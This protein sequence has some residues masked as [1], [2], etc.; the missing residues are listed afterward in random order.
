M[1]KS[2]TKEKRLNVI[3]EL[4]PLGLKWSNQLDLTPEQLYCK[5][6]AKERRDFLGQFFT[7]EPIARL[8]ARWIAHNQPA[9][10]LDPAVGPGVLAR[11]VRSFLPAAEITC[12]DLDPAP[13]ELLASVMSA[14]PYAHFVRADFLTSEL[15]TYDAIIAN[16]PYLRHQNLNYDFDIHAAVGSRN[17]TKLSRLA[18][19]YVLFILEI[20]RKLNAGGRAA[21][22]VPSEW[23]NANF[24][25]ALKEFLHK[26]QLLRKLIYFSHDTLAFEDALTTAAIL[27]IE[28]T[29]A[30]A[31][32]LEVLYINK[33]VG[34]DAVER[35]VFD[36]SFACDEI[37]REHID[38]Q[39]LLH[40]AKWDRLFEMGAHTASDNLIP[41]ATLAKSRRGIA[42]GANEFFH[43]RLSD[44]EKHGIH[45]NSLLPCIGKSQDVPGFIFSQDD[46]ARLENQDARIRLI[47][48]T[49]ELTEREQ[50]YV[51]MGQSDEL[52]QRFL[53]ANRRPW[54]SM[55]SRPASPIWAA[56]FGRRGLRFVWN[57][58]NIFNLTTFHCIYPAGLSER[59][60]ICLVALL[61]SAPIQA[62]AMRH[63]RVYGGGLLKFE[64][65]D[66]LELEVPDVRTLSDAQVEAINRAFLEWDRR[67]RTDPECSSDELNA[68]AQ[69]LIDHIRV[70]PQRAEHPTDFLQTALF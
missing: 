15:P 8:M 68:I 7:P 54:Y 49:G 57:Q 43:L 24:G 39:L 22:I 38:W 45:A 16:P 5:S 33:M 3:G 48:F 34:I 50:E 20:C 25:K 32:E 1:A 27:L 2:G 66:L 14:D 62:R 4:F 60:I 64:P 61:N 21:I 12:I 31:Q 65:K 55:E 6:V 44:V 26:N 42:T 51:K 37:K 29:P 23:M 70:T 47:S 10:V 28:K 56:V 13:L 59:Q 36:P 63:R 41:V 69:K 11:S 40:T 52:D 17:G 19:L 18:N 30:P 58:A 9:T 67:I 46:L 35:A 53:L